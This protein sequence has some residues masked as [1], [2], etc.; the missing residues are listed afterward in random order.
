MPLVLVG[1]KAAVPS[2]TLDRVKET[3]RI[4]VAEQLDCPEDP[5]KPEHVAIWF[6]N[7]GDRGVQDTDLG[8][9]I[10]TGFYP[11]RVNRLQDAMEQ[12]GAHVI[13][14]D[15]TLRCFVWILPQENAAFGIFVATR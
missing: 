7:L 5:V 12:I 13:E 15:D 10:F 14:A 9:V 2:W 1:H 8:V 6:L 11:T 4:R 3:L